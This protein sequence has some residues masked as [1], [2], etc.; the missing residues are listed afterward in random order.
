MPD[1]AKKENHS[2]DDDDLLDDFNAKTGLIFLS[3]PFI[4]LMFLTD[5]L[6]FLISRVVVNPIKRATMRVAAR[7]VARQ[8]LGDDHLGDEIVKISEIP[9]S[10]RAQREEIPASIEEKA[11]E[12]MAVWGKEVVTESYKGLAAMPIIDT[13]GIEMVLKRATLPEAK[14][15]HGQYYKR[16][17]FIECISGLIAGKD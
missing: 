4:H 12:S 14:L 3:S 15:V 16:Q 5:L 2:I 13:S 10:V 1:Y 6:A 17:W 11:L 8:G 7:I 9:P